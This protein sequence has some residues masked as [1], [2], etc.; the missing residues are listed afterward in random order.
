MINNNQNIGYSLFNPNSNQ[1]LK[2]PDDKNK[3]YSLDYVLNQLL[4]ESDSLIMKFRILTEISRDFK[5]LKLK[6]SLKYMKTDENQFNVFEFLDF[7]N[8]KTEIVL[9]DF[10]YLINNIAMNIVKF[11]PLIVKSNFIEDLFYIADFNKNKK[12]TKCILVL[13]DELY[14]TSSSQK[15]LII[16]LNNYPKFKDLISEVILD[17]KNYEIETLKFALIFLRESMI[18]LKSLAT[19]GPYCELK[20]YFEIN[21]VC[22]TIDKLTLHA[23]TDVTNYALLIEKENWSLVDIY[24]CQNTAHMKVDY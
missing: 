2:M 10:I 18:H 22:V 23:D 12:L 16:I 6:E 15:E 9:S 8:R 19:H 3:N 20:T 14:S 5:T 1:I 17:Y 21:E 4:N 13:L 11:N 7:L 24:A